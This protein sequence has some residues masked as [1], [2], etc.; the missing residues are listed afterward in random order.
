MAITSAA[1]AQAKSHFD[2]LDK[3]R[4]PF[5]TMPRVAHA[6]AGSLSRL[7]RRARSVGQL[8]AMPE[9]ARYNRDVI[10]RSRRLLA[11][12][13]LMVALTAC[14]GPGEGVRAQ[15]GFQPYLQKLQGDD[16]RPVYNMLSRELRASISYSEWVA[17]WKESAAERKVQAAELE[18]S[19][20]AQG[21]LE[22]RA[23]LQFADGKTLSL[24]R[25]NKGWTLDQ[26]LVGHT[27]ADSPAD[28][29]SVFLAAIKGRDLHALL[30]ILSAE[31]RTALEER[32]RELQESLDGQL[33]ESWREL[34]LV[35]E[36]RAELNWSHEGV[37][38][39][40]VLVR[41]NGDWHVDDL[42]L[43]PDPLLDEAAPQLPGEP[44]PPAPPFRR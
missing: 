37:R 34:Y 3:G 32:L 18:A 24:R 33:G 43:G 39:K 14:G 41:E 2:D 38:Y 17:M 22:E 12:L 8:F 7:R 15:A 21:V 16:P 5:F 44:P 42:H 19:L 13:A 27:Q 29:L 20:K 28:A 40:V 6:H 25:K 10:G 4:E 26:A 31:R 1:P 36:D 9:P 23:Q 30:Q 11:P 35:S